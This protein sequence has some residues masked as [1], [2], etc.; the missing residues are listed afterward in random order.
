MVT[1]KLS[2]LFCLFSFVL[3]QGAYA[4]LPQ[5][6][7]AWLDKNSATIEKINAVGG[8]AAVADTTV[9][10][11]DEPADQPSAPQPLVANEKFVPENQDP[12]PADENAPAQASNNAF[13]KLLE[14]TAVPA[15][16]TVNQAAP[17]AIPATELVPPSAPS[18]L[19]SPVLVGGAN[20]NAAAPA[21]FNDDSIDQVNTVVNP[22]LQNGIAV[23]AAVATER[24]ALSDLTAG[25][26]DQPSAAY[27]QQT[28]KSN[29][30]LV[31]AGLGAQNVAELLRDGGSVAPA[32]NEAPAVVPEPASGGEV[33]K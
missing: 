2:V 31:Q 9:Q 27:L 8:T 17:R 30:Q 15:G 4:S 7:Q 12:A 18:T 13:Q 33:Q 11:S 22:A 26:T 16:V 21:A 24:I 5:E 14:P 20:E 19:P 28:A 10:P 1:K 6:S 25:T 29:Q 3:N 23:P 32:Q